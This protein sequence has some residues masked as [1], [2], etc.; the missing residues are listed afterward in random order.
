[1]TFKKRWQAK[2]YSKW[3][4][5][6]TTLTTRNIVLHKYG[7]MVLYPEKT[8]TVTQILITGNPKNKKGE[9]KN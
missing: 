8:W 9:K 1:M 4:W 3:L 2:L 7:T 6:K 5:L